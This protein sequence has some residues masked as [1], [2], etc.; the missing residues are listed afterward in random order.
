MLDGLY[1]RMK[2]K[3]KEELND[4]HYLELMDRLYVVLCMINDHIQLHP[5]AECDD[6]L[7]LEIEN[8][9][10]HLS[11]AYQMVGKL[12]SLNLK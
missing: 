3:L 2:K 8:A 6:G 4:G 5:L 11:N 7:K 1:T 12:D 10:N 9:V